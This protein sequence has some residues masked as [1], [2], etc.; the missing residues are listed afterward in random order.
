VSADDAGLVQRCLLGQ[1]GAIQQL[2][3][4]F[5]PEVFGLCVRLLHHRPRRRGRHPGGLPARLPQPAP[6]GPGRG[7]SSRGSWASPST[8][9]APGWPSACAAPELLDYLQDNRPG[10]ARDDSAELLGEIRAAV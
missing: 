9:A 4:R 3:E 8:A 1:A 5:Q 7:R 10:P 2:V 6:L